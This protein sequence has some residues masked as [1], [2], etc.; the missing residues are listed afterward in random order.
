MI[1]KKLL[2]DRL[3]VA[4]HSKPRSCGMKNQRESSDSRSASRHGFD[5][6]GQGDREG[7]KHH[8]TEIKEYFEGQDGCPQY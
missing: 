4:A 1:R 5:R 8:L 7:P 6:E 2:L 3:A